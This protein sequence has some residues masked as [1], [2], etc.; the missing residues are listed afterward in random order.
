MF[1]ALV[2]CSK[3]ILG[4][5]EDTPPLNSQELKFISDHLKR[6]ANPI[7]NAVTDDVS[8]QREE[9]QLAAIVRSLDAWHL[10]MAEAAG[11]VKATHAGNAF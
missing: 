2:I 3:H 11:E 7:L 1:S 6:W 5:F 10:Q 4:P 8:R 9:I